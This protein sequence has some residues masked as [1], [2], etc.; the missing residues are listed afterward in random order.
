M[1]VNKQERE[2]AIVDIT[3]PGDK[4]IV[5]KESEVK[6]Y[7]ELKQKIP[8]MWNTKTVREI[9]IVVGS[10]ASVTKNLE[11]WLESWT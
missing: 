5:E 1:V 8:R 3:V 6:K 9:K 4:R 10:F 11:N 7:Q 2:C